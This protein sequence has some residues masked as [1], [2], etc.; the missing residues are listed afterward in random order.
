MKN[1]T[2]VFLCSN[3]PIPTFLRKIDLLYAS[4]EYDV[5]LIYWQRRKSIVSMPLQA[6][7]HEVNIHRI[8]LPEPRGGLIRRIFLNLIFFVKIAIIIIK[9]KPDAIHNNNMDMLLIS[10]CFKLFHR[11]LRLVLD[12]IDTRELFLKQF[13][14]IL[15]KQIFKKTDLIFVTSPMYISEFLNYKNMCCHNEKMIFI[16]NA[17]SSADFEGFQKKQNN[18]IT[19]GYFGY[20]R[21]QDTIENVVAIIKEL[22]LEGYS[23]S[24]FFAGIGTERPLVEKLASQYEFVK[25]FGPYEYE[26]DLKNLY[27]Q[28]DIIFSMYYLDHNKKIHM[29][30]RYSDAVVCRLP[31][32]VQKGSY[33]AELV[34]KYQTG[35]VMELGKWEEL[36]KLLRKLYLDRS[37]LQEKAKNCIKIYRENIFETYAPEILNAYRQIL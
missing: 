16:P 21:G 28:V 4:G 36:K 22:R 12:L 37:D 20:I 19:L 17:P 24:L 35:Y 1:K 6:K 11:R 7:I 9:T 25:Y 26:K 10:N 5:H 30:C 18:N 15:F 33:L 3:V 32:I 29:S 14:R 27:E 34:E 2:V 23:V 31:I 13:L 8:C